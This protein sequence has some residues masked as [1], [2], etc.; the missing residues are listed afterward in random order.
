MNTIDRLRQMKGK[1]LDRMTEL[2]E[3]GRAEHRELT[4]GESLEYQ[5]KKAWAEDLNKCIATAE[6]EGIAWLRQ[7]DPDSGND[8]MPIDY[9]H[10]DKDAP[11]LRLQ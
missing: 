11:F 10:R 3:R 1:A 7:E 9:A 4:E 5:L 6:A 8:S 2:N